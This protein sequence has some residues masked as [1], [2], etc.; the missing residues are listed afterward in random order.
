M[1]TNGFVSHRLLLFIVF[2]KTISFIHSEE[3]IK[4][5]L[6]SSV[7]LQFDQNRKSGF[8]RLESKL[9]NINFSNLLDDERSIRNRNLLSG[10]GVAAGDVDGDG[11]CDLYFCGLENGNKLYRNLGGWKFSDVTEISKV[12]C[13]GQ[14]S[15]AAAFADIDGDGDLDLLVNALGGGT[16]LFRNDNN[17][18]FTETTNESGLKSNA[19]SMSMTIA[20]IENDG[21]LDIYVTN[22]HPTTIKD[23]PNTKIRVRMINNEPKVITV[24]GVSTSSPELKGRFEI[25]KN[26][27]V[28]EYGEE[29]FLYINDG[30]GLFKKADYRDRFL[31]ESG[32]KL[33]KTPKDWGLAARFCDINQ[34][35]YQDL[36]VCND[37]F[38]PDRIWI[39]DRKGRFRELPKLALR[40]TSTFSMGVDFGDFDRDGDFD[41]FVV[42][43]LSRSHEMR[44]V[45]VSELISS[46][47]NQSVLLSRPQFSRNT[48]QVNRGD[49]TFEEVARY[50]NVEASEWSWGPIFLDV[51]FD[52]YEDILV[53]NGQLR[54]FQNADMAAVI[55]REKNEKGL[56]QSKVLSLLS[57]FPDLRT[58]NVAFRNNKDGTFS[59]YSSQW[60]FDHSGISQGMALADL[61]NDGD[62]DV[63]MNNLLES[64]GI[65]ENLSPN[66]R[67]RI[68]LEGIKNINGIGAKIVLTQNDFVQTQEI[69]CAGRYLSSDH[70]VRTFGVQNRVSDISI[71][72]PSGAI[73]SINSI[74]PNFSYT[75]KEPPLREIQNYAENKIQPLFED[76]SNLLSHSHSDRPYE[77][78]QRQLLIPIKYSQSGPGISWI[79]INSDGFDDLIISN[80]AGG[81]LSVYNF[82][83]GGVIEPVSSKMLLKTNWDQTMILPTFSSKGLVS[84]IVGVSNYESGSTQLPSAAFYD[85]PKQKTSAIRSGIN[86]ST[87]PMC[88]ADI[89]GDGVLEVFIGG[90]IIPAQYPAP[91]DSALMEFENGRS[92]ALYKWNK[93][94]MVQSAIF[95]DV[96]GDEK[97]E[98][99]ITQHWGA[100]RVFTW[101]D[102]EWNPIE[103]TDKLGLSKLTGWWNGVA[104]GDFNNDGLIDIV[105]TNWGLN[106]RN[107]P[108]INKPNRVYYGD[109][110]GDGTTAAIEASLI[111]NEW[112]P[113]RRLN[114]LRAALPPIRENI[115]NFEDLGK[116]NVRSAFGSIIE[117]AKFLDVVEFR[118]GIFINNSN[119]SMEFIPL[120]DNAQL[121][122]SFGVVVEDFDGDTFNDIFLS[123][124][125]FATNPEYSRSDS[126]RGLILKG[127][128]KGG[129]SAMTSKES[130]IKIYGEQRACA[131]SDFNHDG[132]MD[133][134]VS[135]NSAT[136]KLY[137]N[138]NGSSGIRIRLKGSI[139]N[140]YAIGAKI[141]S[142][143]PRFLK[144]IQ[145][146]SGYW[147][148]NSSTLV[149][150]NSDRDIILKVTWPNSKNVEYII[151]ADSKSLELHINGKVINL[152]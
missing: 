6:W 84:L 53:T 89:N 27:N 79:D 66:P 7:K 92:K 77:D 117:K 147:A 2:I 74:E 145:S 9:T 133:L 118:S 142:T 141:I 93:L 25:S 50:S 151:P 47:E 146:G 34:D 73:Q 113:D 90:Q 132:R 11:L 39:N 49:N 138:A 82:K 101:N 152:K 98:L 67:I 37:L 149:F 28:L 68:Q 106:W 109:L 134:V 23:R 65:Y 120:P 129:F 121:T 105:A 5:D 15:T 14:D 71:T 76:I 32:G 131:A 57:K 94:G 116:S 85:F 111:D 135:Q 33:S 88:Q 112:K 56:S 16:R 87:G 115:L 43:M 36:Y 140:P 44:H 99:I 114:I 64:A 96:F 75:F 136:T 128:G 4:S 83:D 54:D 35:G 107:K 72:W 150:P 31:N 123:Q 52:G 55:D 58:P 102:N 127:N 21:D 130:G 41:F 137:Q 125:F 24:N 78:F 110:Y 100:L 13:F 45:Q 10:S 60:G 46:N 91:A 148:N 3:I 97:P 122:P 17:L 95:S 38:T 19:G 143:K 86:G 22:F 63:I 70:S 103:I 144:E 81:K 108:T 12:S 62:M 59:D 40:N 42:D 1:N 139:K 80:G 18:N 119:A 126:G 48:L 20:D 69:I 8:K 104:T 61:D 124:N 51:D 30:N 26:R 29:D